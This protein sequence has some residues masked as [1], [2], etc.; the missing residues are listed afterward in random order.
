MSFGNQGN[1][2]K[3]VALIASPFFDASIQQIFPSILMGNELYLVPEDLKRDGDELAK[4]S[5]LI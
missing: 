2:R 3:R 4:L 1:M 5:M